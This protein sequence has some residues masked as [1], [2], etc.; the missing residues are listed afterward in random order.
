MGEDQKKVIECP[1][2]TVLEGSNDDEVVAVAGERLE[3]LGRLSNPPQ[4]PTCSELEVH[5][6]PGESPASWQGGELWTHVYN[7]A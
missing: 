6:G 5:A 1:C 2:G 7:A 3:P 4:L